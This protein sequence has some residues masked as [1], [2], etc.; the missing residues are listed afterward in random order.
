MGYLH[1]SVIRAREDVTENDT[2]VSTFLAEVD[3]TQSLCSFPFCFNSWW[4]FCSISLFG[5]DAGIWWCSFSESD[6]STNFGFALLRRHWTIS[7]ALS[8]ILYTF[9]II[10]SWIFAK[11][12]AF[13]LDWE[14]DTF[15]WTKSEG[16]PKSWN[17]A[18][19]VQFTQ[20]DLYIAPI[21]CS[22][23]KL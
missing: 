6:G 14:S 3:L 11:L 17:S 1:A 10:D 9:R 12:S 5:S 2:P 19:Y 23:D 20:I 15:T 22:T 13:F 16:Q 18:L 4:C 7:L 8:N 21:N